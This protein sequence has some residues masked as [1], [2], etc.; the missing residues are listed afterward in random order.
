MILSIASGEKTTEWVASPTLQKNI[1]S[2]LPL[3]LSVNAHSLGFICPRYKKPV[4]EISAITPLK[5]RS[6]EFR[7]MLWPL[8]LIISALLLRNDVLSV[9]V[10]WWT[11]RS[12]WIPSKLTQNLKVNLLKLHFRVLNTVIFS[13]PSLLAAHARDF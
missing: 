5:W 12:C 11:G 8:V 2:H 9:I 7:F 13:F 4:S 6:I 3:V 1:V 10:A